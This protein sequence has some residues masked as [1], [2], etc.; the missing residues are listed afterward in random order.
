MSGSRLPGYDSLVLLR[1]S[2]RFREPPL[3]NLDG[4]IARDGTVRYHCRGSGGLRR[5]RRAPEG[6]QREF[7]LPRPGEGG[8]EEAN[9]GRPGA[10]TRRLYGEEDPGCPHRPTSTRAA[11]PPGLPSP[12]RDW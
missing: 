2:R 1:V 9:A 8:R 4:T 7:D 6:T 10:W 12:T 5:S 3:Q 11:R